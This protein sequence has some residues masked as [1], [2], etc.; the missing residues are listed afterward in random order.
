MAGSTHDRLDEFLQEQSSEGER[1][2]QGVFTIDAE[3]AWERMSA[4]SQPF[5]TA[6]VLKLVQAAGRE[7]CASLQVTQQSHA[8]TFTF[9]GAGWSWEAVGAALM[10]VAEGGQTSLDHLAT[11]L[12]WLAK[13]VQHPFQLLLA[14]GH[15]VA[16]DGSAFSAERLEESA[17]TCPSL[18]VEH[19]T[20]EQKASWIGKLT[21]PGID[22]A[23]SVATSL[24][25]RASTSMVP[26]KLDGRWVNGVPRDCRYALGNGARPLM[27]IS[28]PPTSELPPFAAPLTH[29]WSEA[30]SDVP[31]VELTGVSRAR[32]SSQVHGVVVLLTAFLERR[33]LARGI[34]AMRVK[35]VRH[36]PQNRSSH[37]LWVLDGVVICEEELRL[38][39]PVGFLMVVSADGL[40]TD[41]SGFGVIQDEAH[42]RRRSEALIEMLARL[43]EVCGDFTRFDV[44]RQGMS[45]KKGQMISAAVGVLF[46]LPLGI[47]LGFNTHKTLGQD[48]ELEQEMERAYL[49]GLRQLRSRVKKMLDAEV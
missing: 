40:R 20:V 28:S 8:T 33:E 16:W 9:V 38:D 42:S 41:L 47:M 46:C 19:C 2:S 32:G 34:S 37:L 27:L 25:F 26:L 44:S 5:S 14:D 21:R 4:Q 35:R 43:G 29:E 36:V 1:E 48:A 7:G 45:S 11:G 39:T 17:G 15:R 23:A 3:L 24:Q 13:G 12:R 31:Q 6:W 22:F 49:E 18:S 10:T 30:S